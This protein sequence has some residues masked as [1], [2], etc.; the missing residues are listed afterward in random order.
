MKTSLLLALVAS[1]LQE[2]LDAATLEQLGYQPSAL[3]VHSKPE[4][5]PSL[6]NTTGSCVS[7][8][9]LSSKM[10]TDMEN[11]KFNMRK[12]QE[13]EKLFNG[14][15]AVIES[16]NR[17]TGVNYTEYSKNLTNIYALMINNYHACFNVIATIQMGANCLLASGDATRHVK[18]NGVE[19]TVNISY[20]NTGRRI[21]DICLP[22]VDA[23]CTAMTTQSVTRPKI[24][25][26]ETFY[27]TFGDN[28]GN[29]CANISASIQCGASCFKQGV[30]AFMDM[31]RPFRYDFIPD[32]EDIAVMQEFYNQNVATGSSFFET[33]DMEM[34]RLQQIIPR[35][36]VLV[37]GETDLD[38]LKIGANSG[39][40]IITSEGRPQVLA[41]LLAALTLFAL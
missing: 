15:R 12:L 39:V 27:T 18:I 30:A 2:C 9:G 7:V 4:I 32:D 13:L 40:S 20:V 5:C 19:T 29:N 21:F 33:P 37:D 34:R 35:R 16:Q 28:L 17:S 6:F 26:T 11:L 36:V 31:F 38:L 24:V 8:E 10:K 1:S 3:T 23:I 14:Y 25:A 22:I 41:A